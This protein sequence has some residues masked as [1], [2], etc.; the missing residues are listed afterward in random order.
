[1][2]SEKQH[3]GKAEYNKNFLNEIFVNKPHAETYPDWGI[4]VVFYTAYH[5]VHAYF[6]R[7]LDAQ[8]A[9]PDDHITCLKNGFATHPFLLGGL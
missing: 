8:E 3:L 9:H 6:A 7:K 5:Y 1:M 2:P 4:V